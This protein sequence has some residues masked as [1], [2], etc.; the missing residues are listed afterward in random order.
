MYFTQQRWYSQLKPIG[1]ETS[2]GMIRA[3]RSLDHINQE[4][5]TIDSSRSQNILPDISKPQV[6][7]NKPSLL[8]KE[9][10]EPEIKY[11]NKW[12]EQVN[13]QKVAV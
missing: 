8:R 10:P 9:N 4:A 11:P 6:S 3:D 13:L 5:N 2:M 12:R 7:M 1:T